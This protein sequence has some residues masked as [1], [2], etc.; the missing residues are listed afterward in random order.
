M[1]IVMA[2]LIYFVLIALVLTG[3]A[4]AWEH[5]ARWSGRA[6]RWGWLAALTG[7]VT[8]PWLLRL[9]P[10]RGWTEAVPAVTALR[11]DAL[12]LTPGASVGSMWGAQ[13]VGVLMWATASVLMLAYVVLL[14]VRLMRASRRWRV[15]QMEGG[16]VL[17]TAATGPAALGVRR[18]MVVLPSWVME[19]ESELRSLLL[20]HE[21]AHVEA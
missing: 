7:S 11:L 1:M 6:A 5:S 21:R 19:L 10:E 8:L 2:W 12:T 3:A 18:G 15:E 17:M 16:P 20:R 14:L 9:V 13:D 4:A